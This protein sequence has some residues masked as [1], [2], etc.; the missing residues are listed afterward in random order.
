MGYAISPIVEAIVRDDKNTS[1]VLDLMAVPEWSGIYVLGCFARY[2]T[3]YSQQVRALNLVYG[4]YK[5]D[6][7][8]GSSRIVVIGGGAAGL[9]AAVAAA[10]LG[11]TVTLLEKLDAPMG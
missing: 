2:V 10:R 3:V 9:T 1:E 7:L 6:K 4:L 8:N 5:T 11:A